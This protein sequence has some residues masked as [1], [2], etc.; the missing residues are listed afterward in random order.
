MRWHFSHMLF[1]HC[2]SDI[3]GCCYMFRCTDTRQKTVKLTVTE[4]L[5]SRVVTPSIWEPTGHPDGTQYRGSNLVSK[6][7]ISLCEQVASEMEG[8]DAKSQLSIKYCSSSFW[9]L[10][11]SQYSTQNNK[12]GSKFIISMVSLNFSVSYLCA[13]IYVAYV[14]DKKCV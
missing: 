13:W 3:S 8:T 6:D 5:T 7:E 1:T 2:R 10:R 9:N 4:D 14:N 12:V 11:V